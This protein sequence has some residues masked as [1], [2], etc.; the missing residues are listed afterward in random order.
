MKGDF[1][2]RKS[3]SSKPYSPLSLELGEDKPNHLGPEKGMIVMMVIVMVMV[4][5]MVL[6]MVMVM[7]M[8]MKTFLDLG[9]GFRDAGTSFSQNSVAARGHY[10]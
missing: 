7:V 1:E 3:L 4:M 6:V 8:V 9:C 5:V 2:I 10:H